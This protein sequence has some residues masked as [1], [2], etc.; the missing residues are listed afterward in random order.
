MSDFEAHLQALR[1]K[2]RS[3]IPQRIDK[4]VQALK[5]GDRERAIRSSHQLKGTAS[6]Y[7]IPSLA[8]IM[9]EIERTLRESEG[10]IP[11]P[12][13]ARFIEMATSWSE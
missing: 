13:S 5:A 12:E 11:A 2:F 1:E 3:T 10:P 6:S 4:V 8:S 9:E 7:A